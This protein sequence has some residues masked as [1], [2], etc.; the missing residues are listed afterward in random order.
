VAQAVGF[1]LEILH[2]DVHD[3]YLAKLQL[4]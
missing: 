2:A 3:Q 1:E 4:T